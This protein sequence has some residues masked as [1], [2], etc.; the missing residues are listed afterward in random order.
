MKLR[1]LGAV[2]VL[3]DGAPARLGGP[4]QKTVLSVMAAELGR[5]VSS[6]RLIDS[7]WGEETPSGARH[8][9]QTYVSNLRS[10]LGDVVVR[11]GSGYRLELPREQVDAVRFE[12]EVAAARTLL[13]D[14]PLEAAT[15]LRDALGLW[16]GHAYADQVGSPAIDLEARRLEE[17]R[18]NALEDRIEA[19]L[20]LGLHAELA[21]ELEVLAAEHPLRERFRSQQMLALYRSGRQAEALRAYQKTQTH[22]GEELGIDPSPLLRE[23]EQRILEQD[24][25]LE[26]PTESRVENMAFL[27]TNVEDSSLLRELHPGMMQ[28]ALALHDRILDEAVGEAGG[29]VFEHSGDGICAVFPDV[30]RAVV[31]AQAAQM[32]LASVDW[33]EGPPL[34]VRIAIDVGEVESKGTDYLG[35]P[36][37][38]CARLMAAGHGGQVLL[39]ADA[40]TAL[41]EAPG[42]GWQV[43]AFGEYRLKGLG[44]P[45]QV[46]QLTVEGLPSDFP[47]LV[48]DRPPPRLPGAGLGRSVRGYELREQVGGGDFGIVYRAYQPSVGR[49]VAVKVIRPELVNQPAFVR[50]FEAEAQVVASLEHPHIVPLYDFWRDPDGA[51]LVMRWMRGGSLRR[52]LDRGPWNLKPALRLLTEIGQALSYAH[53]QEV[54][55]RDL[56]PS[57]VLLDEEGNA[58]LSDFGIAARLIDA[59]ESGRPQSSSPAYLAPEE[60]RGEPLRPASDMY[61]LGLLAFEV[62]SGRRPPMDEPLPS[63]HVLRPEIPAAV[64]EVIAKGLKEDPGSR[65]SSVELF[66]T[67]LSEALGEQSAVEPIGYTP[68]RNPY[69][70]LH[71]FEERDAQD[72]FGRDAAVAELVEAVAE[73]RL[74]AVVGPS[75]IGKSS[76]VRAGLIPVLRAG[77]LAGS[78][79]WLFTHLL[80]GAYPFEELEAALLRVAVESPAS[81][82][83]KLSRDERGL[84][85]VIKQV[86]PPAT[87][88]VLVIDQ[89][90]ELFTLT[91]DA[92]TRRHFLDT[93]A[94]VAS[95]P[96]SRV[97]VVLTLRADFFDRPLRYPQ[98]GELLRVGMVALTTPTEEELV[99][100]VE[101]P[102]EG[103]GVR[104]EPRLVQEIVTE[105]QEQPGALPLLQYALTE[106]FASRT[107]DLLTIPGY[108]ATGRVLGALG[109]RAEELYGQLDRRGQETARQ[110]FLRLVTVSETAEDTRRRVLKRELRGLGVDPK[111]L[112]EVLDRYGTYRLL[113][114]DRDP[115][116]R[117]PTVEV[118]HEA[119]LSEWPRLRDWVTERREDLLLHR[120]LAEAVAEWESSSRDPEFLLQRGRLDHFETWAS[121]TDLLRTQGEREFLAASRVEEDRRR[122]RLTRRRWSIVAVLA[123]AVIVIATLALSA[124]ERARVATTRELA[125]AAVANLEADPELSILLALEAAATVRSTDGSVLREVEEVLHQAVTSSRIVVTIPGAGSIADWSSSGDLVAMAGGEDPGNVELRAAGTGA[126]IRSWKADD[127]AVS[128]IAFSPDGSMLVTAGDSG[129]GVWNPL[130]GDPVLELDR[131][132]VAGLSFSADGRFL[133]G[134]STVEAVVWDFTS[135]RRVGEFPVGRLFTQATALSPDGSQLAVASDVTADVYAVKTGEV[136]W[137]LGPHVFDVTDVDWSSD[138][139]RVVTSSIGGIVQVWDATSGELL[140]SLIGG[141]IS[142][143]NR[144]GSLLITGVDI[145]A[146][147]IRGRFRLLLS[148]PGRAVDVSDAGFDAAGMKVLTA[149]KDATV[150]IWDLSQ[151]GDAEW[152]NL[153]AQPDW[154][155]DVAFSPDGQWILGSVPDSTVRIWDAATGEQVLTLS[156]HEH[157]GD[158]GGEGVGGI[159]VSADGRRI[160]TAG[161]DLTARVWDAAT[162]LELFTFDGHTEWLDEVRFSPDGR[163]LAT[164][165]L[166]RTTRII[167]VAT[168][169]ELR[170]LQI[171]S[172][173][174]VVFASPSLQF[175]PDGATLVT[176]SW[177]GFVRV[178]DPETGV[179]L[180]QIEVG[181]RLDNIALHPDGSRI[182]VVSDEVASIWDLT[183]GKEVATLTGHPAFGVAFSPDGRVAVGSHQDGLLR[184]WDP[185]DG[186]VMLLRGH[187]SFVTAVAFSPDGRRLASLGTEG[188]IRVWAVDLDELITLAERE[189]TRSF[190]DEECRQYLHV[191]ACP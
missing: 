107:S 143:W 66:L 159:A 113:T 115:L 28:P 43:K 42:S 103:V 70:G 137:T 26:L 187:L 10:E 175:S 96:R 116:T 179:Q 85:R 156:G 41:S 183:T 48:I 174:K 82:I 46:F 118:A 139:S 68:C 119:L 109:R 128:D 120:R 39:S 150:R 3:V 76:V 102:A 146:I 130:S 162:G 158:D 35:P 55:H 104:F 112:E 149:E 37:N 11:E 94:S 58:Y 138:G 34:K 29:R 79:E 73:H 7:L 172:V 154:N 136:L 117:G 67:A 151:S 81:L 80:P 74:V 75:G 164:A 2:E 8:T 84:A 145:W 87:Q 121:A 177:D 97:R 178:W 147:D 27:F 152:L 40:H 5:V 140:N 25:T 98:F 13:A 32:A 72:F 49:E 134:A 92:D 122:R 15:R 17:L 141:E 89:F 31:A 166:D 6:D 30:A 168:G 90:E 125:A 170:S 95:D 51:Y 144:D 180:Q 59:S 124:R 20:A 38:R 163:L 182:V 105:V 19:E 160:A 101:K 53:R 57:N 173:P 155:S 60:L 21:G 44:R 9:L 171:A 106:L 23:L 127:T 188:T 189:L 63:F 161:R 50:L 191:K 88:V 83:E 99:Q 78:R 62:F 135:G 64:D 14:R 12:D 86:L 110:V 190:T 65:F 123:V 153:A 91:V 1:V 4:K 61:A 167:D 93:L 22:L 157:P 169:R 18:L 114:F 100:G 56:K 132:P 176:A 24:P 133:A 69:K 52:A 185:L 184:V 36:L 131:A 181:G 148:L 142:N 126:L 45:Q 33:G 71:A 16:R 47:P 54:V 165:S 108:H 111:V 186:S 129:V 77:A